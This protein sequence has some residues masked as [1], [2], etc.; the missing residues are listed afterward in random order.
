[1]SFASLEP[2]VVESHSSLHRIVERDAAHGLEAFIV[3]TPESREI[4]NNSLTVGVRYTT[5]LEAACAHAL[6]A[7]A[8]AKRWSFHEEKTVVLHLLRGG[9]NFGLRGALGTAFGWNRHASS[10]LSAQRVRSST[11]PNEWFI[12]ESGY[13]KLHLPDSAEIIF[14]DV[15]ATG[16]SLEYALEQLISLVQAEKK[17]VRS[18]L[19][20]TIGGARSEAIL[21]KIDTECRRL[22]PS[23]K[24]AAVV[25]L[26]G[27]FA[28]AEDNTP[29]RIK[30]TGTDL[31]RR[32][33]L[34][35]PLF[36]KSQF[37]NPA[38]PLERCTIYDAG[39]RAF[40]LPE[41]FA[42]LLDYWQGTAKL[43][44]AG[45]TFK[46]LLQERFP[47]LDSERFGEVSLAAVANKQREL[48]RTTA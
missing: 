18:I 7:L 40:W 37:E 23:Y 25:Y 26:E 44:E 10:F 33:S 35:A 6:R 46:E 47:E 48:I 36:I 29:I 43:A 15:V 38:Y 8:A 14:G 13:Q 27:R 4:C 1:M 12:S 30:Y 20:F 31:L 42:D 45:V 2:L 41:Y 22:F 32:D 17:Q 5:L 39:S 9:L 28:V 34:L 11:D 21:T 3:S 16:T 19:F 24:G